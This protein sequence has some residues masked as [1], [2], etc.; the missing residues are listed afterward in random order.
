MKR[1]LTAV[2]ALLATLAANASTT[3]PVQ[4]TIVPADNANINDKEIILLCF[5]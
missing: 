5:I 4:G 3:L 2:V 1:L